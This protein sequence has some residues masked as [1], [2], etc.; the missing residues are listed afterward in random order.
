MS[1]SL[2]EAVAF[3][4]FTRKHNLN[5]EQTHND[6]IWYLLNFITNK[7]LRKI[8]YGNTQPIEKK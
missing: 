7:I 8:L 3:S 2:F 4:D 6:F 1:L 5:I